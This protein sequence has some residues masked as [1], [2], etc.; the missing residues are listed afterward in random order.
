MCNFKSTEEMPD[1]LALTETWL[2][3]NSHENLTGYKSYHT[4]REI[5][6]SGGV[7]LFIKEEFVSNPIS[8]ASFANESI[9]VITAELEHENK[10]W[11]II[12]IYRPIRGPAHQFIDY[13]AEILN[14]ERIVNKEILIVG[15]FNINLLQDSSS[16][17][18]LLEQL[19]SYH[20]LPVINKPTRFSPSGIDRPSLLDHI[21][22]NRITNYECGIIINDTTDH[23]PTYIHIPTT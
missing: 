22:F 9:E 17:N 8:S 14:H 2:E 5:G 1:I 12:A 7:S 6:L 3:S 4:V 16:R 20:F 11:V 13:L 15:D 23:F 10:T 21:W 18:I 19:N